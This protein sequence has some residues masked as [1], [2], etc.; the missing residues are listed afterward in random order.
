MRPGR[1]VGEERVE[2]DRV[3][4][5]Y[6]GFL[7][8]VYI[9]EIEPLVAVGDLLAVGRPDRIIVEGGRVA[10]RDLF[11]L[12]HSVLAAEMQRIFARLIGEVGDPFAI[13][14]PGRATLH[15]A[16]RVGQVADVA[17][18]GG[19][20]KDFAARLEDG[21]RAGGGEFRPR[22]AVA[23]FHIARS[24]LRQIARDANVQFL[25]LARF[26]VEEIQG[27]EL[28]VDNRARPRCRCLDVQPVVLEYL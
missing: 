18:F 1:D 4:Y 25:R 22:D 5:L 24:H 27:A 10:E 15:D 23:D 21:S 28:L 7:L 11:H 14:R 19:H 12:A 20:G 17:L 8:Y 16:R 6:R 26:Q 2:V 13:G 3:V 9:P